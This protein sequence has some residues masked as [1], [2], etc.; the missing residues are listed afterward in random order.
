MLNPNVRY[1]IPERIKFIDDQ[2]ADGPTLISLADSDS[3]V[4]SYDPDKLIVTYFD[5]GKTPSSPRDMLDHSGTLSPVTRQIAEATGAQITSENYILNA[6]WAVFRR[7]PGVE[8]IDLAKRIQLDY[9]QHVSQVLAA[10]TSLPCEYEPRLYDPY[11]DYSPD[12]HPE[13][14]TGDG[15]R[16]DTN[17][18]P[19]R[20]GVEGTGFWDRAD[21][22]GLG[23][24]AYLFESRMIQ[25]HGCM[26][27]KVYGIY[28]QI[29]QLQRPRVFVF[30]S[31]CYA[32]HPDLP[33]SGGLGSYMDDS[34]LRVPNPNNPNDLT[35]WDCTPL[36][37]RDIVDQGDH[38]H[39]TQVC[40]VVAARQH[41]S[42]GIRGTAPYGQVLPL[43]IA[44]NSGA[45]LEWEAEALIKSFQHHLLTGDCSVVCWPYGGLQGTTSPHLDTLYAISSFKTYLATIGINDNY[46]IVMSAGNEGDDA[47]QYAYTSA[48]LDPVLSSWFLTAGAFG[49]DEQRSPISNYPTLEH[50]TSVTI[51]A[52]SSGIYYVASIW[53]D[54]ERPYSWSGGTSYC[55]PQVAG[56][57]AVLQLAAPEL[58]TQQ[59][60]DHLRTNSRLHKWGQIDEPLE[61]WEPGGVIVPYLDGSRL[62]TWVDVF[63][64]RGNKAADPVQ[65]VSGQPITAK[66]HFAPAPVNDA[67]RFQKVVFMLSQQAD[68]NGP[69]VVLGETTQGIAH[70]DDYPDTLFYSINFNPDL[71]SSWPQTYGYLR[72]ELRLNSVGA[73]K[74]PT[75]ITYPIKALF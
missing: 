49:A 67:S 75:Y 35:Y 39:G 66:V 25:V 40:G 72:V 6:N 74:R 73:A 19:I 54:P 17:G 41:N 9:A 21:S 53:P 30:D 45:S 50:P 63:A 58:T 32:L 23:E 57:I 71:L 46:M 52:P 11:I 55:A 56:V 16:D 62:L 18:H 15:I 44:I 13:W 3:L 22:F 8:L 28:P 29:W 4:W 1:S 20:P 33:F 37:S 64:P 7:P 26:Y 36:N 70:V 47:S 5:S 69:T 38:F 2:F 34:L 10:Y 12:S 51:A 14:T 65:L 68:G 61:P 43:R 42:I 48:A 27:S 31:G 59:I 60:K 24:V